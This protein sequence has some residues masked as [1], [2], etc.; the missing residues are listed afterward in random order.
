MASGQEIGS[1]SHHGDTHLQSQPLELQ[2]EGFLAPDQ[3]GLQSKILSQNHHNHQ[4]QQKKCKK[5]EN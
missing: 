3:P 4:Q 2:E 5:T 1:G